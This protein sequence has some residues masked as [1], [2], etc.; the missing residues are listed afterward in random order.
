M[1]EQIPVEQTIKIGDYYFNANEL[2]EKTILGRIDAIP[3]E[4]IDFG[5]E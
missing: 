5:E 2:A 1:A 3:Q 4:D